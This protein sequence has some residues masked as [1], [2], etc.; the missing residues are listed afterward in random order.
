MRELT[1]AQPC[2]FAG[3]DYLY[4]GGRIH[5]RKNPCEGCGAKPNINNTL[6]ALP[7]AKIKGLHGD[8]SGSFSTPLLPQIISGDDWGFVVSTLFVSI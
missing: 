7:Q 3:L 5:P 8:F 2:G 6:T 4:R 1:L